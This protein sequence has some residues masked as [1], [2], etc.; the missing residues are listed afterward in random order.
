MLL[1]GRFERSRAF[2]VGGRV[3][4]VTGAALAGSRSE[5]TRDPAAATAPRRA[6]GPER[7]L[8]RTLRKASALAPCRRRLHVRTRSDPGPGPVIRRLPSQ[9]LGR[10]LD[11]RSLLRSGAPPGPIVSHVPGRLAR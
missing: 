2:V 10:D 7:L 4:G 3:G 11:Q 8:V 5:C 9:L 6:P 1:R